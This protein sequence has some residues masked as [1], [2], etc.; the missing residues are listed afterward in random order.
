MRFRIPISFL[1][2]SL[3]LTNLGIGKNAY[4]LPYKN[5]VAISRRTSKGSLLLPNGDKYVGDFVNGKFNGT[6]TYSW[7][8]GDKYVGDF[9]NGKF[10]GTCT[11]TQANGD[12][13]YGKWLNGIQMN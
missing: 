2:T 8:N 11:F 10:N 5:L 7:L 12:I 13:T 4:A 1:L 6:G 9:V 3:F